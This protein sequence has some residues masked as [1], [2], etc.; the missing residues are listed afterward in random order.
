MLSGIHAVKI[1]VPKDQA[2]KGIN[3]QIQVTEAEILKRTI[4]RLHRHLAPFRSRVALPVHDEIVCQIHH[5]ELELIPTIKRMIEDQRLRAPIG[6]DVAI[7]RTCWAEK[8]PY[9]NPAAARAL[10]PPESVAEAA[11]Q[12]L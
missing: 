6:C 5:D 11:C 2:Y 7:A 4:V 1:A 12:P 10:A 9:V 8:Q 3:Y